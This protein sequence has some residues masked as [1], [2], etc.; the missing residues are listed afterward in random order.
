MKFKVGDKVRLTREITHDDLAEIP[1][2]LHGYEV[3]KELGCN[4]FEVKNISEE[5]VNFSFE[6]IYIS[7]PSNDWWLKSEWFE[8]AEQPKPIEPQVGDVWGNEDKSKVV[9]VLGKF[10][11]NGFDFV[12][13]L[14]LR[15]E[16][17]GVANFSR[18]QFFFDK[19][20]AFLHRPQKPKK[21]PK[22]VA[23]TPKKQEEKWEPVIEP[24]INPQDCFRKGNKIKWITHGIYE[25]I[26]T[27]NKK[28]EFNL[29]FGLD[30]A[31]HRAHIK[32]HE[33]RIA[34]MLKEDAKR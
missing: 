6:S 20:P 2:L 24:G 19:F 21:Q 13:Y 15:G 11:R 10:E 28:D 31:W 29:Q 25:G 8:L 5:N 7:L 17:K 14:G 1:I 9:R 16:C 32:Y 18:K 4:I 22:P 33:A 26:A 12:S 27:C 30:L 34:K 23:E 3:I